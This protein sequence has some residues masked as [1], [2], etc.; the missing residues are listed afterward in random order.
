MT[1]SLF[2]ASLLVVAAVLV[3]QPGVRGEGPARRLDKDTFMDMEGVSTPAM[4]PDGRFVVFTREWI[5]QMKDQTRSNLWI[6]DVSGGRIRELTRGAWRDSAPVWAPDSN[7]L[8]F[9]S[10][11]D[12]TNQVDVM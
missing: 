12:G 5:D 4:S 8:A 3:P 6:A 9:L 10:D 1:R 11:R 2:G 7:R